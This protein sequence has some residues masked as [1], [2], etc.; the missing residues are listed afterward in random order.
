MFVVI[1]VWTTTVF[2]MTVESDYSVK[3]GALRP[4]QKIIV[5]RRNN[6]N[7]ERLMVGVFQLNKVRVW[8]KCVCLYATFAYPQLRILPPAFTQSTQFAAVLVPETMHAI[9]KL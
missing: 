6:N 9:Y 2:V 1:S 3:S 8:V 7:N 5:Q 4:L